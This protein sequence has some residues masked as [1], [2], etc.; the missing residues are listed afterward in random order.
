MIEVPESIVEVLK[1]N[2]FKLEPVSKTGIIAL[3]KKFPNLCEQ[4][5]KLVEAVGHI[6]TE[7]WAITHEPFSLLHGNNCPIPAEFEAY[8]N[9]LMARNFGRPIVPLFKPEEMFVFSPSGSS[10]DFCLRNDKSD[11]VYTVDWVTLEITSNNQTF[12]EFVFE[13]LRPFLNRQ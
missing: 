5:I 7:H 2:K 11:M 3:R 4:F 13:S 12:F 6:S 9:E 8:K 1:S 10:W